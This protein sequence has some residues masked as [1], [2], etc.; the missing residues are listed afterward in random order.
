MQLAVHPEFKEARSKRLPLQQQPVKSVCRK[1][2][3]ITGCLFFSWKLTIAK[4]NVQWY[5]GIWTHS[6][7]IS[8]YVQMASGEKKV[9]KTLEGR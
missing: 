8:Q 9:P 7:W 3:L 6:T 4:G 5:R 1:M 2:N